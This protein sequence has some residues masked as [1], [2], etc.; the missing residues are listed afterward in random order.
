MRKPGVPG[1]LRHKAFADFSLKGQGRGKW[2]PAVTAISCTIPY[3]SPVSVLI[4]VAKPKRPG[5]AQ[6]SPE[7]L[8][9]QGDWACLLLWV[10]GV[11]E[12]G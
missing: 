11:V 12:M 3:H 1:E 7:H 10:L 2:N 4:R 6:G 8:L 9:E 5:M